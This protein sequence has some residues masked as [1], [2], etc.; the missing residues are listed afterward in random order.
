MI[1]IFIITM[2]LTISTKGLFLFTIVQVRIFFFP[3][4]YKSFQNI[5]ERRGN[6][7]IK[8]KSSLKIR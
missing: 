5:Q 6:A 3:T 1:M 8:E 7:N 4:V 2:T